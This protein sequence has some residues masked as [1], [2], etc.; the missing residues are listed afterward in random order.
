MSNLMGNHL[1]GV[2]NL[3]LHG[4]VSSHVYLVVDVFVLLLLG[5]SSPQG[6]TPL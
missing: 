2:W 4:L 6:S 5:S 3:G 1:W